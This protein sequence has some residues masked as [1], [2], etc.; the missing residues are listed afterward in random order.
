M[1]A[2]KKEKRLYFKI[3][4]HVISVLK[5]DYE[6]KV[7]DCSKVEILVWT[8]N[9]P[10][11]KFEHNDVAQTVAE[12]EE[13]LYLKGFE[14]PE[15]LIDEEIIEALK[16]RK[17]RKEKNMSY[18]I[19][20]EDNIFEIECE[21]TINGQVFYID[22]NFKK[23][24]S[25]EEIKVVKQ[26]GVEDVCDFYIKK[27]KEP[28]SD[29]VKTG[30]K[31]SDVL[32][33]KQQ[34]TKL[35]LYDYFAMIWTK[36]KGPVCVAKVVDLDENGS[37]IWETV[38]QKEKVVFRELDFT[39]NSWDKKCWEDKWI[40]LSLKE[41]LTDYSDCLSGDGSGT[42]IYSDGEKYYKGPEVDCHNCPW[43]DDGILIHQYDFGKIRIKEIEEAL[44]I[45]KYKVVGVFWFGK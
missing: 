45:G 27:S 22:T 34:Q 4:N 31:Y 12:Q 8:E 25:K 28:G 2:D 43:C 23:I 36:D 11:Y 33:E 35:E 9:E 44:S 30:N 21:K 10:F 29:Y 17:K 13:V 3:G 20:T 15:S 19:R 24:G 38:F 42:Y 14:T 41:F 6:K 16:T 7:I 40:H 32:D 37:P 39:E 26:S 1:E 5:S 18:L